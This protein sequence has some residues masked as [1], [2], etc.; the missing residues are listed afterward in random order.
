MDA[1]TKWPRGLCR[2]EAARYVG[3]GTTLFD[4]MVLDG[5]MP[6]PRIIN[7]R[8]V[9]DRLQLDDAFNELPHRGSE[10]LKKVFALL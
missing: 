9:W 2:D 3:I 5:R 6:Q 10:N 1:D 7:S 4:Q 8:T